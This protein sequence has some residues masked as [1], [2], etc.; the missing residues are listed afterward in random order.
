MKQVTFPLFN[1]ELNLDPIAFHLFGIPVYWYAILIVASLILALALC[2]KKEGLFEISYEDILD[3]SIYL[4]P[5]AFVCARLYYIIFNL[6]YYTSFERIINIKDGGLAIYGGIIGGVITIYFFCK[7]RNISVLNLI[8]YLVPLLALGQSIGRWGNFINVEAYG[9]QTNLPWKMGIF[10]DSGIQYVH[11]TFFYES[12]VTL[13]LFILLT[14][15]SKKRK[16][17]GEIACWYLVIYSFARFWIEGLRIDSLMLGSF[18]ISQIVSAL[19]F[20]LFTVLLIINL[21]KQRKKSIIEIVTGNIYKGFFIT[22]IA[23]MYGERKIC[24]DEDNWLSNWS[25]CSS[26]NDLAFDY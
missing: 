20:C 6:S 7:K 4:I 8:D 19:L 10:T 11:P 12:I 23:H 18:R 13:F 24:Y 16:F 22:F 3:L 25:S 14:K 26:Y 1:L 2:K 9:A 15:L 21:K 5:I 17:K